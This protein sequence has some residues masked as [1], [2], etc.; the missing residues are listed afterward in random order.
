MYK[1]TIQLCFFLCILFSGPNSH[2][3]VSPVVIQTDFKLGAWQPLPED[4]IKS[5]SVD[6]ALGEI[7]KTRRFAFFT[8]PQP[9]LKMGSLSISI[10]LVEAAQTATVSILLQQLDG[11][12]I[13]STHSES[14]NNKNYDGIYKQFQKA[15]EMAGRKIVKILE[16]RPANIT[17]IDVHPRD[18]A[19]IRYLETQ[20][21]SINNRIIQQ[22]DND[23]SRSEAKL[24]FIVNELSSMR[25]AYTELAKKEDITK[26][27]V[28]IDKVLSEVGEL[29]MKID[30][31]PTT[32]INVKQHYTIDNPL[33]GQNKISAKSEPGQDDEKAHKLYNEAQQFKRSKAYRKAEFNL[34]KAMRLTISSGLSALILDELNYSLPMFEAQALAIDLG[35]NFQLYSQSGKDKIILGRI[36]SIYNKALIN[37]QHDFQRTR[38][39]QQK[40]DQHHTTSNA[41]DAVVSTQNKSHAHTIHMYMQQKRMMLGEY[42]DKN[43]FKELIKQ[44]GL[45]FDVLSYKISDDKYSAKLSSVS[46]GVF[47]LKL[48]DYG[49]SEVE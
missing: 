16:S 12:S 15:G 20:I 25:S 1:R 39:I 37:N 4:K 45:K 38:E 3:D 41:M 35:R 2:A 10:K 30:N 11:E 31:K 6:S 48:N 22:P 24:E 18:Q 32:Q 23:S 17:N 13:S 27:G 21:M 14:L 9:G 40:L 29:S 26:Q 46:G 44:A 33:L 49:R 42:P 28:K 8:R 36:E 19:R 7:S 34:L 5:A 47:S 43:G